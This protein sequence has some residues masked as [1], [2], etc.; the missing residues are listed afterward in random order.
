MFFAFS[1]LFPYTDDMGIEISILLAILFAFTA[2]YFSIRQSLLLKRSIDMVFFKVMVEKR[3]SDADEKHDTIR[4]FKEQISIM[5]QLLISM[6][7]LHSSSWTSKFF[8]QEYISFEYV[9]H[10]QEIYFYIVVPKKAKILV[11]KQII[12][13]YPHALILEDNEVNIFKDRRVV[14]GGVLWLKKP[15][16]LPI[17]PYTKLETDGMNAILSAL[18]K[19]S[20]HE[21]SVVQILL[22]P[23]EDDWQAKVKKHL[24]RLEKKGKWKLSLNPFRWLADIFWI[25][26]E[27]PDEKKKHDTPE[28]KENIDEDGLIKEKMKKTWYAALIRIVTTWDDAMVVDAQVKNIV[29][30][31]S[32]FTAPAYNKFNLKKGTSQDLVIRHYIYR[33]FPLF[34]TPDILNIEELATLYHFPHHKYNKQPEIRWQ[35]FKA[36]KAPANTPT[37]WLFLGNNIYRGDVKPVYMKPEDR[38]RHFYIIGKTGTGKSVMIENMAKQDISAW[39][40]MACLDP[41]GDLAKALINYVP[42]ERADQV[43]YFDP[44]DTT[45]PMG[46][47]LLE[48]DT[49]DEKQTITQEATSIMIKLF[50]NEVFWPRIQDYFRNGCLT[51]LDFPQGGAITDLIRLF[52]DDSFQNARRATIRNPIVRGWWDYTYAKMGDRE[53]GE[54]IPFWAAKFWQFVTNTLMRNIV[55]Q[56]KSAFNIKDVMDNEKILLISVSKGILWDLNSSLLGMILVTKMQ[57]AA[58]ARQ[59]MDA[60]LRKDFY[61]YIDEFQNFITESIESILSEARKYRLALIVAHQYIGQ[62]QKSDALT[63]SNVNLKD[64]IFGNVG[65]LMSYKI[66]PED[67][68]FMAKQFAPQYSD[69]DFINMDRGKA[70]LKLSIDNQP[71]PGFEISIPYDPNNRGDAKLGAAIK[72]LSRL[73]YWRDREFVE[74]EIIYRI[75]NS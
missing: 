58:M 71:S 28:E 14:R 72:E 23:I 73:K 53:K 64:A 63:K 7:S 17:R 37:A 68:E 59:S 4:D 9:A 61:L 27:D 39:H 29:S 6:K 30:A 47:N 52:T 41:H 2:L 67:A 75:G 11:E 44:A 66:G 5:E 69:Q 48:A 32:Q 8:W 60:K 33:Q 65:S 49:D 1:P 20:M 56:T 10:E 51:L 36:Q 3:E 74:K 43:V 22:Q 18:G 16:Y 57:A 35:N 15:F 50:G 25:L 19:T 38:F 34:F 62:L 54:M 24:K 21:S 12:G 31:F 26:S 42:K 40:G 13:F 70:A 55:G 46:L 45:R